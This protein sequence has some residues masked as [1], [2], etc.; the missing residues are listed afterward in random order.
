M[1]FLNC[2]VVSEEILRLDKCPSHIVNRQGRTR[3]HPC[4]RVMSHQRLALIVAGL[5][6]W[7]CT[8]CSS[9]ITTDTE[10]LPDTRLAPLGSETISN[11]GY[12]LGALAESPKSPDLLVLV[13]MSGGGKR[14]AAFSY[15]ALQG[16]R[17][18][19]IRTAQGPASLLQEVDGIAGVSGGSFTAAYYGLY[20]DA[21]FG[22]FESD[23]LYRNTERNIWGIYLL[24]WNWTWIFDPTVGTN[25]FMERVY[26]REM[27][28]GA[29]FTDLAQAG[30]PLIAIG[31]TDIAFGSPFLFTQETFDLLCADLDRFPVARAVA[32]SNGFP[33]LFSPVTLINHAAE[34]GGRKPGWLRRVTDAQRNDPRSRIGHEAK[35]AERYLDPDQVKYV[36]LIDGGVADNLALRGAGAT[37]QTVS[38]SAEGIAANRV[39]R[40]RRVLL[41]SIDGQGAQDTSV[42][43]RRIVGGLFSIFGLVS[44]TKIDRFNFE[45]ILVVDDQVQ[46]FAAAIRSARCAIGPVID[47][48]PCGDVAGLLVHV[49]LSAL[50]DS[51]LKQQLLAIPTGLTLR[52]SD[53][54]LLISA[55]RSAVTESD[56]LRA[57]LS[58]YEALQSKGGPREV[59]VSRPGR[60]EAATARFGNAAQRR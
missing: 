7:F 18:L 11:G 44:G 34:C 13:A 33:G 16:M 17:D 43:Q 55:G 36:H 21:A 20:R 6:L 27:F 42:A 47:G 39:D 51:P 31:G 29:R 28:R 46:A 3:V 54:D 26:D 59:G 9:I 49:S 58:N 40:L 1:V 53:V 14:S 5:L 4:T 45:T 60:P 37:M 22:R 41:L 48:T 57:F 52:H 24:P 12:R 19:V 15:G 32:A 50:P 2:P 25:D 35:A 10:P 30:R 23:F 56:T 8:G 38:L